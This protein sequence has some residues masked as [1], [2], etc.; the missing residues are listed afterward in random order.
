MV[1]FFVCVHRL[2][3]HGH[4]FADITPSAAA[5]RKVKVRILLDAVR[6]S[7]EFGYTQIRAHFIGFDCKKM[8]ELFVLVICRS[9]HTSS[10]SEQRS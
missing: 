7:H 5:R 6:T 10:H 8:F 4:S 2:L 1:L 3:L 9:G